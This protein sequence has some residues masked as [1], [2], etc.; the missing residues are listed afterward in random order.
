MDIAE[1]VPF[2]SAA[3]LIISIG[4]S[5]YAWLTARSKVNEE[6]LTALAERVEAKAG[7]DGLQDVELKCETLERR[8]Q[9]IEGEMKHMPD[10]AAAHRLELAI[11]DLNGKLA[12]LDE[13]L[14][15][16]A[17]MNEHIQRFMMER[18]K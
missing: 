15:P 4:G 13:R 6:R 7:R 9:A 5:V 1:I 17:A 12:T 11:A 2:L 18:V 8:V 16:V 3:A 10:R 14:K